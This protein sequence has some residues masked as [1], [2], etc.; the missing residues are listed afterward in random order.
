MYL[1][2]IFPMDEDTGK[3]V[4][5]TSFDIWLALLDW[6][7][8]MFVF[9][10][11]FTVLFKNHFAALFGRGDIQISWGDKVIKLKELSDGVDQE[12]DPIKEEIQALHD[13]VK[14]LGGGGEQKEDTPEAEVVSDEQK[15]SIEKRLQDALQDPRYRWRTITRLATAAGIPESQALDLLRENGKVDLSVSKTQRQIAKLKS[16]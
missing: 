8:L 10:M 11:V 1:E 3:E 9:L 4:V 2:G 15:A 6:P 7:F 14:A 16:R 13:E 12:L 5:S